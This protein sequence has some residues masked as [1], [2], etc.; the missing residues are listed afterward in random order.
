MFVRLSHDVL[1]A[2]RVAIKLIFKG[3]ASQGDEERSDEETSAFEM[4]L[5]ETNAKHNLVK[6]TISYSLCFH[7]THTRVRPYEKKV[8]FLHN[9]RTKESAPTVL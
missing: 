9:G 1:C 7:E 8:V 2:A 6:I 5:T 3:C 4:V